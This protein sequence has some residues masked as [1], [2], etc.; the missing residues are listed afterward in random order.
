MN[1]DL[2]NESS[3]SNS[4]HS[5]V[6]LS[7]KASKRSFDEVD[8]VGGEDGQTDGTLSPTSPGAHISVTVRTHTLILHHRSK[9]ITNSLVLTFR[10]LYGFSSF[11][12][13]T[14]T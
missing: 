11:P 13:T 10:F 2:E 1:W 12:S 4:N 5:S 8:S 7:S 6:T 3:L 9:T 14:A